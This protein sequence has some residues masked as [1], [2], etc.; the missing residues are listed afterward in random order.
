MMTFDFDVNELAWTG[1][2]QRFLRNLFYTRIFKTTLFFNPHLDISF[3]G[4]TGLPP[5][6]PLA[7]AKAGSNHHGQ[8][9]KISLSPHWDKQT[10]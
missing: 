6:T 2:I 3:I 5:P 4:T 7:A 1:N 8:S 9:N 10:I